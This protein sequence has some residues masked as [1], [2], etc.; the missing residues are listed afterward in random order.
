MTYTTITTLRLPLN[1]HSRVAVQSRADAWF[2]K[3]K[4]MTTTKST[5]M[6]VPICVQ[7]FAGPVHHA[8]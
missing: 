2:V 5:T 4:S 1:A 7:M 8:A 6:K 3:K